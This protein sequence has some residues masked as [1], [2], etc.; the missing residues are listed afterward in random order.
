MKKEMEILK[1]LT[2]IVLSLMVSF[3]L[4]DEIPGVHFDEA[5]HANTA[6]I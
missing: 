4:P 1:I 2:I 6:K 5:R 3:Y